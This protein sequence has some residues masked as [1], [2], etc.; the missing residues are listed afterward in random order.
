MT[1]NDEATATSEEPK[2]NSGR[3][4]V[5]IGTR[6]RTKRRSLGLTLDDVAGKAGLTRS[7]ISDIERDQTSPSVASL[8]SLCEA[9]GITIGSLFQESVGA[10][11]RSNSRVPIEF[12]GIGVSDSLLSPGNKC[13]IQA[14]WSEMD[15]GA[16]GGKE[17]YRVQAEE[18]FVLVIQGAITMTL[19]DKDYTLKKGDAF[20]FDPRREHTFANASSSQKAIAVF[21][22]TPPIY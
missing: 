10:V 20:T 13:R 11:V 17:L 6:L 18:E 21:A 16:T 8:L 14:I 12:G 9:L 4:A 22:F 3:R 2:P 15:P 7:F 19:E 5:K 1:R